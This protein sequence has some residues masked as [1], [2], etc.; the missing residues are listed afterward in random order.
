MGKVRP[1]HKKNSALNGERATHVK[2][3]GKKETAGIR[4]AVDKK[5]IRE[6]LRPLNC[7]EGDE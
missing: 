6:E 4:R 2:K 5:V 7:D 3:S 1:G